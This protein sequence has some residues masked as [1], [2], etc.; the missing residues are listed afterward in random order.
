MASG[1]AHMRASADGARP[2]KK[3]RTAT[4]S[5]HNSKRGTIARVRLH[6]FMSYR[7][8]EIADPGSQLNCIVGPN[9][10]GKSSI[11][12][13]MCVGLGGPLK[14]TERGDQIKSCVHGEGQHKDEKGQLITSGFVETE[15][16]DGVSPGRNLTVRL[17]FNIENKKEWRMDGVLV[18]E[19]K[20]KDTMEGL[21]IQV[22]NPLQFL[23][24]DKVGQFSNMSPQELLKH[25]EMAIGPEVYK[26]HQQLIELDKEVL[27]VEQR[28]TTEKKKL[29][30]LERIN[31]ALEQD[32]ERFRRLQENKRRLDGFRGKKTWVE[33][34]VLEK[35]AVDEHA[36]YTTKKAEYKEAQA[37]Y[38]KKTEENAPLENAKKEFEKKLKEANQRALKAD[39]ERIQVYSE[40]EKGGELKEGLETEIGKLDKQLDKLRKKR[41]EEEE[42]LSRLESEITTKRAQLNAAKSGEDPAARRISLQTAFDAARRDAQDAQTDLRNHES[43]TAE[44][45][46]ALQQAKANLEELNN[47]AFRKMQKVA[48]PTG[49]KHAAELANWVDAVKDDKAAGPR[50]VINS[51]GPL[52]M[53]I[54]VPDPSHQKLCE[55]AIGAK[56]AFAFLA[57][58][59]EARTALNKKVA[60]MKWNVNV[61]RYSGAAFTSS[62]RPSS[63]DMARFGVTKWL[64]EAVSIAPENRD[65]ILGT[66][67]DLTAID[68]YLLGTKR[69]QEKIEELQQYLAENQVDQVTILTP[70]R[71]YRVQ[72]SK[73]GNRALINTT[74]NPRARNDLYAIA[75]D[76][77]QLENAQAAFE[78]AKHAFSEHTD[79]KAQ[80]QERLTHLNEAKQQKQQE[81]TT[82]NEGFSGIKVLEERRDLY[83]QRVEVARRE[84]AAFDVGAKRAELQEKLVQAARKEAQ[85]LARLG[86][87]QLARTKACTEEYGARLTVK[88]ATRQLA[89]AKE[90][91]EQAAREVDALKRQV[92][93]AKEQTKAANDAAAKKKSEAKR[94]APHFERDA[95]SGL[96]GGEQ[97]HEDEWYAIPGDLKELDAE[98]ESLEEDIASSDDDDGKTLRDYEKR[99]EEIEAAKGTASDTQAEIEAK[100]EHLNSLVADWKPKL[101]EMITIVDDNFSAYFERFRCV[102]HVE[103]VDG[104]KRSPQTGEPEGPDDFAQYKVH[105]KVQWRSNESLHVLGEGGRD[106]G[107]ERSVA[108]MVYLISLQ[109]INPAPFRVVD[110]I[111]QAMDS[112]NERHVFEC[113]THACKEGGKQYFLLT[114]KLLPDL[115]Y[116]EET[117]VQLV[118][119]GPYAVNRAALT[120]NKFC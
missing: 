55:D 115:D 12:C 40:I 3:L 114:P 72:R 47:V 88:V 19:K 81:L 97:K 84:E 52:L 22:D 99:C 31:R 32:V 83:K 59:D 64:D 96:R 69:T 39:N 107:G 76:P 106:S 120:L 35:M 38:T 104:R 11:V 87:A 43:H 94:A 58:S 102:G 54:D 78:S 71:T 110:E 57:L 89:D 65:Q 67:K 85:L 117:A 44:L 95:R 5:A 86:K 74:Q 26:Q 56:Y 111:N 42:K 90:A 41:E 75:A 6:N 34:E 7:D 36:K 108:T 15:L 73:Y 4:E 66:L 118:F 16:V 9:G 50:D 79:R 45:N 53:K 21:N 10:T 100:R 49:N 77:K 116:G 28:L 93:E 91:A 24:Q 80:L 68:K 17:D 23:P 30:D 48:S 112:T 105:I 46:A 98:I 70:E 82:F 33:A 20:V 119:N 62:K 63:S 113:I 101:E 2:A 25:T 8:A 13:A 29:E 103:L 27:G 51:I 37:Q 14:L 18:T 61:Y 92:E 109:S 1:A 60:E